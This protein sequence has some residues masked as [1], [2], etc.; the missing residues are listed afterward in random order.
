MKRGAKPGTTREGSAQHRL[1][2]MGVGDVHWIETSLERWN[3]DMRV[4]SVPRTRRLG[5]APGAEFT[6]RLYT[7][8]GASSAGDIHYLIR[9]ERTK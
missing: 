1:A 4:I 9:L 2:T 5:V 7:A 6:T 8:V 3:H